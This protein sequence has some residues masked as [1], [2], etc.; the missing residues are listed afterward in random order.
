[1]INLIQPITVQQ[2]YNGITHARRCA[3]WNWWWRMVD[4]DDDD[5]FPSPEPRTVSRSALPRKNRAWRWLH[6]VD[7]DNSFSL[8]FSV[9]MWFYSIREVV[10]GAT[11]WGQP[12]WACQER[13]APLVARPSRRSILLESFLSSRCHVSWSSQS[14]T[15]R[16]W[17]W[18][19]QRSYEVQPGSWRL[20]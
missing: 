16:Q 14:K 8:I 2:A 1:M 7:H 11:R 10:C 18:S 17:W 13:G 5:N 6:L 3:S 12:T 4:D 20:C 15:S 9:N 19:N